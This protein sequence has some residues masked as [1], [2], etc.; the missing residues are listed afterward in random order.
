MPEDEVDVFD[1]GFLISELLEDAE[2]TGPRLFGIARR[3]GAAWQVEHQHPLARP[4]LQTPHDPL[5]PFGETFLERTRPADFIG[6]LPD[7]DLFIDDEVLEGRTH[8]ATDRLFERRPGLVVATECG[9]CAAA[10]E[11]RIGKGANELDAVV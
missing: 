10:H 3:L 9:K 8:P 1:R 6:S 7:R 4:R 2:E 11:V 5:P